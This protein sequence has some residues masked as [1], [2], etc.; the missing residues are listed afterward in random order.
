MIRGLIPRAARTVAVTGAIF[1]ALTVATGAWA[2][3]THFV[4]YHCLVTTVCAARL[5]LEGAAGG[6]QCGG[7]SLLRVVHSF[8]R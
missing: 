7:S 8:G 3:H 2:Y 4:K 6:C 1:C 5:G